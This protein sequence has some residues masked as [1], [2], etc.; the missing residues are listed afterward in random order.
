MKK[1][2]FI[3]ALLISTI[4]LSAKFKIIPS[5]QVIQ[6]SGEFKDKFSYGYGINVNAQYMIIDKIGIGVGIGL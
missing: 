1:I 6:A 4:S 2:L 3:A 5:L